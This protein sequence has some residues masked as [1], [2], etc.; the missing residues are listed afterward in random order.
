MLRSVSV[1][2]WYKAIKIASD[3]NIIKEDVPVISPA[4]L[5]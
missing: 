4:F 3:S 1:C 5:C 2:I